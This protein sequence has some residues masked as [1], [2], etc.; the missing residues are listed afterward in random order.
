MCK[1]IFWDRMAELL[2]FCSQVKF[3]K[4]LQE[5]W[6]L[7]P[8]A[9]RRTILRTPHGAKTCW[10]CQPPA[11]K[12][13][14]LVWVKPCS[15]ILSQI[16]KFFISFAE[17]SKLLDFWPCYAGNTYLP[18]C[19]SLHFHFPGWLFMLQSKNNTSDR[20]TTKFLKFYKKLLVFEGLQ[21][22]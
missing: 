13:R 18:Y 9:N 15:A 21:D 5:Q 6:T 16:F 7:A 10:E 2:F 3:K 14:M 8:V 17:F 4:T 22:H 19:T 11:E 1:A 20:G 12:A